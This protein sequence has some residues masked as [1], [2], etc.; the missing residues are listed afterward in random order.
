MVEVEDRIIVIEALVKETEGFSGEE[1]LDVYVRTLCNLI[2]FIV[3]NHNEKI[4]LKL[5]N[6]E[7]PLEEVK[8]IRKKK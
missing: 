1:I 8:Q 2:Q 4:T 3:M 6:F 5:S 7:I